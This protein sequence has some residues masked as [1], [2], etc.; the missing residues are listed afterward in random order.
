MRDA[1]QPLHIKYRPQTFDE[2]VG[3]ESVTESLKTILSRD[4]G[5]VKSFLFTG[6]S[7]CG[8]T[9]LARIIASELGCEGMNFYEYNSANTRG[10][11]TIREIANNC[12]FA[13]LSGRVKI[14]LLDECHKLTGDA[15]NA[16]LKILEDTPQHVRFI[17]CTTDPDKLLKTIKTRCS[18]FQVKELT[19]AKMLKLLNWVCSEEKVKLSNEVVNKITECAD[20]SPRQALVLLDQ[21]ID[22]TDDKLALETIINSTV[23]E[24]SVLD[25]CQ[26]LLGNANW[27]TIAVIIK[28]MDEEPEKIRNAVL[29]YMNKVLLSK[30]NDRASDIIEIFKDNWF[31][32]G[33]AGLTQS[34]YILTKNKK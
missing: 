26:N 2:V 6:N 14:Y 32:S 29:G 24:K 20:G 4:K 23:D 28:A 11:D 18:T 13:P 7:G 34:C 3:N 33:A 27:T 5:E 1:S 21:V 8:K 15:A 10:V 9:T 22:L 30:P 16:L 19:K 25:L 31:Y 12:K 17:L